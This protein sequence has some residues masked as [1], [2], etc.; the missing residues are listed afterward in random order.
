MEKDQQ[1]TWE[2]RRPES[3]SDSQEGIHNLDAGAAGVGEAH[4]SDEGG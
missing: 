3:Y 4:I 2:A 1:G